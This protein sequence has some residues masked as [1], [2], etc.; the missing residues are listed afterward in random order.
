MTLFV[1]W[2]L[3]CTYCAFRFGALRTFI[4]AGIFIALGYLWLEGV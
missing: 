3:L 4:G 1:T 2:F